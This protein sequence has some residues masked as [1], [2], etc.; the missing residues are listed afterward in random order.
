VTF[1]AWAALV[2][3]LVVLLLAD[4][5]LLHRRDARGLDPQ[6]RVVDRRV[7]RQRVAARDATRRE[8]RL[9]PL[10]AAHPSV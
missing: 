8:D 10:V 3:G 2:V 4:L 7:D 9:G 6:R 5:F 1:S